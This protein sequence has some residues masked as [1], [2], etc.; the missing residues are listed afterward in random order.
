MINYVLQPPCSGAALALEA[1]AVG[2]QSVRIERI[3]GRATVG[4]E[5]PAPNPET[6]RLRQLLE[7]PE[8]TRS[9]SLLTL[10]LGGRRRLVA[11]VAGREAAEDGGPGEGD[12]GPMALEPQEQ[13]AGEDKVLGSRVELPAESSAAE[14]R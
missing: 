7:T 5:V 8:F 6:I 14:N 13:V 3:P 12:Q 10:A 9:Q 1:W 4:I 2:G 11:A